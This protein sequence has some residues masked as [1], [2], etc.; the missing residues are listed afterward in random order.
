MA[1]MLMLLF[2]L[3]PLGGCAQWREKTP[4]Q[5]DS[6]PDKALNQAQ[7]E[8][9]RF[10]RPVWARGAAGRGLESTWGRIGRVS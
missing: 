5:E 10:D 8:G 4:P 2:V 9:E 7:R 6:G 1:R 3:A